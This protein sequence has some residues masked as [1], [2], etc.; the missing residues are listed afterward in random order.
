MLN[1]A[2]FNAGKA[3]GIFGKNTRNALIRFQRAKGIAVDGVAGKQTYRTLINHLSTQA[4]KTAK[5][6][7]SSSQ[8]TGQTLRKGS[9]GQAVRDLQSML[10]VAG[11]GNIVGA[12]DGIYG[13]K[14]EA[15]VKAFQKNNGLKVDGIAGKQT[16]ALLQKRAAEKTSY[17][18]PK[19]ITIQNLEGE[20]SNTRND[21]HFRLN[22]NVKI[23]QRL[24]LSF[25]IKFNSNMKVTQS[26]K[27]IKI[28]APNKD[29]LEINFNNFINAKLKGSV[30]YNT[31]YQETFNFGGLKFENKLV[32]P[33]DALVPD[34]SFIDPQGYLKMA[35][36]IHSANKTIDFGNVLGLKNKKGFESVKID[37]KFELVQNYKVKKNYYSSMLAVV[38]AP[39]PV[40]MVK[41]LKGKQLYDSIKTFFQPAYR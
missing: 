41:S 36:T 10:R 33:I 30:Y 5:T 19:K 17:K 2:G 23:E 28:E 35:T 1:K 29:T 24:S 25:E 6:S 3:D 22:K 32:S 16:Y 27:T 26:G 20:I 11:Y 14:T 37:L 9:R 31:T 15:A 40:K 34:S 7:T 21:V 18:P 8:W 38:G 13:S 39:I 12:A 4:K